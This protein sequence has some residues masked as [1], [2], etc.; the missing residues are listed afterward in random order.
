VLVPDYNPA[1]DEE[2]SGD[3]EVY[4]DNASEMR[5]AGLRR[6]RGI[7][8]MRRA[9]RED[10]WATR[11]RNSVEKEMVRHVLRRK[12]AGRSEGISDVEITGVGSGGSG[13]SSDGEGAGARRRRPDGE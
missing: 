6:R 7:S 2:V 1:T 8:D 13:E 9:A 4:H 5:T 11:R 3:V 12:R 10:G